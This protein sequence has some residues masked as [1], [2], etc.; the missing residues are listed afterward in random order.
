MKKIVENEVILIESQI[1]FQEHMLST[2]VCPIVGEQVQKPSF[3]MMK[4]EIKVDEAKCEDMIMVQEDVKAM[5]ISHQDDLNVDL[6]ILCQDVILVDTK[7]EEFFHEDGLSVDV[8]P[9][10]RPPEE[11]KEV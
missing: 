6:S 10:G 1:E 4:S 7:M 8:I 2:I 11:N 3:M 9:T 5:E